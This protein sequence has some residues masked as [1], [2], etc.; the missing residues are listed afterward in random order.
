M[1]AWWQQLAA[2][3]RLDDELGATG[4]GEF[5]RAQADQLDET[6]THTTATAQR[7]A[8][9]AVLAWTTALAGAQ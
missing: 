7:A 5:V 4:A 6:L 3:T 2:A 9:A 1:D 8:V